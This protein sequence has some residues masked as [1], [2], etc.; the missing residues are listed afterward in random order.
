MFPKILK[1]GSKA[2]IIF[3]SCLDKPRSLQQVMKAWGYN[4]QAGALYRPDI[5]KEMMDIGM[6]KIAGV[7]K[8]VFYYS[9]FDWLDREIIRV[10]EKEKDLGKNPFHDLTFP[11]FEPLKERSKRKKLISF[12]DSEKVR[13]TFF[14]LERVK[15]LF[16]NSHEIARRYGAN[17]I[18]YPLVGLMYYKLFDKKTRKQYE[19]L[20]IA[21]GYIQPLVSILNTLGYLKSIDEKELEDIEVI[22]EIKEILVNMAKRTGLLG[23]GERLKI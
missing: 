20:L 7:R 15:T 5:L 2:W 22:P 8:H 17:L 13:Q 18:F 4:A 12:L 21:I 1:R 16:R 9:L 14:K 11:I 6:I 19:K 23:R 3:V 10:I